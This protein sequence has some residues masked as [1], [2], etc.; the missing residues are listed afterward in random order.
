MCV[1]S[2][3]CVETN[4]C[5]HVTRVPMSV[6]QVHSTLRSHETLETR[7]SKRRIRLMRIRTCIH[8]PLRFH[9]TRWRQP[10]SSFCTHPLCPIFGYKAGAPH[11]KCELAMIRDPATASQETV[12][13]SIAFSDTLR[14][15]ADANSDE[16]WHRLQVTI[17]VS[18]DAMLV[19][20]DPLLC[21]DR[22][23]RGTS[24][25]LTQ[26]LSL[27]SSSSLS[28]SSL[29]LSRPILVDRLARPSRYDGS[30]EA[31][32]MWEWLAHA[33]FGTTHGLVDRS[34]CAWHAFSGHELGQCTVGGRGYCCTT[35]ST[36]GVA[37]KC[38]R[39]ASGLRRVVD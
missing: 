31:V 29:S 33:P 3:D 2:H 16:E 20:R 12:T 36:A 28:L 27:S 14:H 21:V 11:I 23:C 5:G 9:S 15:S 26:R 24:K 6:L 39:R 10:T 22:F 38:S 4:A 19:P 37:T 34:G 30:V 25:R 35:L 32:S 8:T 17:R 13:T 7:V 18:P 1:C